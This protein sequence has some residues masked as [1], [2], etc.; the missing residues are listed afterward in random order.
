MRKAK[1]RT[2]LAVLAA[3]ATTTVCSSGPAAASTIGDGGAS[4]VT[5]N[6]CRGAHCVVGELEATIYP[7]GLG[8]D[9]V[10]FSCKVIAT[11][12]AAST[13][14]SEC[15]VGP[16]QAKLLPLSAPGSVVATA[17]EGTFPAGSVAEAC[18]GG[19]AVFVESVIGPSPLGDRQCGDVILI[20][21]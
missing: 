7:T 21:V 14:V 5:F 8:V 1:I 20:T 15:N 9:L 4:G 3:A 12:T 17:G 13:T 11:A 2:F 19:S 16:V 10:T 18:V 6:I